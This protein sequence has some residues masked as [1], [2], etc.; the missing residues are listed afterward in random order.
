MKQRSRRIHGLILKQS[1]PPTEKKR[2]A[3]APFERRFRALREAG[4]PTTA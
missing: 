4:A 3:L 2:L 1:P